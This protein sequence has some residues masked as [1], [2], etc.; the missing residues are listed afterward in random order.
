MTIGSRGGS[1][2]QP[3]DQDQ[4]IERV[5][6]CDTSP[7]QTERESRTRRQG[8]A[9]TFHHRRRPGDH[10]FYIPLATELAR[11]FTV[12]NFDRRGRGQSGDTQPYTVECE[13]DDLA[14]LADDAG[15]PVL[16]YGQSAGSAFALRAAAAGLSIA[17]LVLADPPYGR[18][19]DADEAAAR[20]RQA[21]AAA[22]IQAFHDRGDHRGNAAFFLSG[23]G[24]PPQEVD[25]L[26]AS[27]AGQMMIDSARALPY[28]YSMVGDGL[29]PNE[30]AARVDAPTLILAAETAPATAQAL[31][32]IMPRAELQTLRASTHDL[33]PTE[34]AAAVLPFFR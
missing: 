32:E 19:S 3:T 20:A 25:D 16:V 5:R 11:H 4:A 29:V 13:L 6:E 15:E 8:R 14:A 23:F 33:A 10:R 2:N 21:E 28:D 12:Y 24:L 9:L 17:K 22:T 18:H 1:N 7:R 34:I 26:L 31:A 30:L 27:P